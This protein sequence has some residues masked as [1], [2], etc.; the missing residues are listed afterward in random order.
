MTEFLHE[1]VKEREW[2]TRVT[3]LLESDPWRYSTPPPPFT[4]NI[5]IPPNEYELRGPY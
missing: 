5:P 3:E 2:N 4:G 1:L